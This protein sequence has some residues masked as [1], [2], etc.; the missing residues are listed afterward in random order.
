M[1][2]NKFKEVIR[3]QYLEKI[4]E[5]V[6]VPI[7]KVLTGIRKS[8]KSTILKQIQ[9]HLLKTNTNIITIDM[10]KEEN[11]IRFSSSIKLTNYLKTKVNTTNRFHIFIDEIQELPN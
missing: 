2:Q 1:N 5:Y 8:G 4:E 3:K 6:G 7:I 11:K 9:E 10:N